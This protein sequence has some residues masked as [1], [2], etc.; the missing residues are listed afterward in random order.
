MLERF[1]ASNGIV[2]E[3]SSLVRTVASLKDGVNT[4]LVTTLVH[5]HFDEGT[6][7]AMFGHLDKPIYQA[8]EEFCNSLGIY[9]M[10]RARK[11]GRRKKIK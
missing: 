5:Q 6:F 10:K 8:L 4:D 1:K 2:I 7:R 9:K 3:H 11:D